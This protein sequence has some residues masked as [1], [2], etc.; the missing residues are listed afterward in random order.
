MGEYLPL[1]EPNAHIS[2][3][4]SGIAKQLRT[5][6][7]R[8]ERPGPVQTKKIRAVCSRCNNS[9][10]SALEEEAKPIL[11]RA[12]TSQ[13]LIV[14]PS[15][16]ERLSKWA[17]LKAIV[18]EH[19]S[20]D[21][22]T[23]AD[24][25]S[26]FRSMQAIPSYFRVFANMH[27]S[28]TQAAYVRHSATF[29]L[30]LNGPKPSLPKGVNRN[31]QLTTLLVGPLC[32]HVSATRVDGAP[33]G[34]LDPVRPMACLHPIS[35]ATVDLGLIPVLTDIDLHLNSR[36][37]QRLIDHPRVKYGGELPVP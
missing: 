17:V 31:V 15:E 20:G 1:S 32:L 26:N 19:A 18:G 25:R 11:L 30:T 12:L 10:M 33:N 7:R 22:L 4:H 13:G 29:S 28:T 24:D 14:G 16:A 8:S 9:W 6:Q 5:L 37:I 23:P 21:H 3:L 35:S 36:A 34:L 27:A 2:E